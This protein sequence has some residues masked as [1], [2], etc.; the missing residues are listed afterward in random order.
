[1]F[2][3]RR[4]LPPILPLVTDDRMGDFLMSVTAFPFGCGKDVARQLLQARNVAT[5]LRSRPGFDQGISDEDIAYQLADARRVQAVL[6]MI[7]IIKPEDAITRELEDRTMTHRQDREVPNLRRAVCVHVDARGRSRRALTVLRRRGE[8][9]ASTFPRTCRGAGR[10]R[11]S[12]ET[13]MNINHK[14]NT[15]IGDE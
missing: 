11:S 2:T 3:L 1:V 4:S 10:G 13:A 5:E 8:N 14:L 15:R 12:R 7:A 6:A 9:A